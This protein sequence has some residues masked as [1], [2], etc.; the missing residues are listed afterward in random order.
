PRRALTRNISG[1]PS[2]VPVGRIPVESPCPRSF[3]PG[4]LPSPSEAASSKP[5]GR[6][7]CS[8]HRNTNTASPGSLALPDELLTVHESHCQTLLVSVHPALGR[9][10]FPPKDRSP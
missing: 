2:C 10:R 6:P 5:V 4:G 8:R 1:T 9:S 3:A 7:T